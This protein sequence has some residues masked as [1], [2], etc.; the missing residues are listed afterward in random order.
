MVSDE[1]QRQP[2]PDAADAVNTSRTQVRNKEAAYR[3]IHIRWRGEVSF[4]ILFV[5]YCFTSNSRIFHSYGDVTICRWR[6]SNFGLYSARMA[7]EQ[8]G[9]F[10]VPTFTATRDLGFYCLIRRTGTDQ[11]RHRDSNSQPHDPK[12]S[13]LPTE[14]PG[15]LLFYVFLTWYSLMISDEYCPIHI[16][17]WGVVTFW[18]SYEWFYWLFGY[19]EIHR[20]N[21]FWFLTGYS[22]MIGDK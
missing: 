17:S 22:L 7:I 15:R 9:F 12:S 13:V 5:W 1:K 2:E 6:A 21:R 10:N 8:W 11:W 14:P 16:R 4:W 19:E 18:L 3:P 20:E